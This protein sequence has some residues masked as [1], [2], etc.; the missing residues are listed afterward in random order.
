MD[1]KIQLFENERIRS[2]WDGKKKNGTFLL[3]MWLLL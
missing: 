1:S 3:S 2:A